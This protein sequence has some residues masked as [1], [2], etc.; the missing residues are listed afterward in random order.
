M[1]FDN[2]K[3]TTKMRRDSQRVLITVLL[4]LISFLLGMLTAPVAPVE[5]S[6]TPQNDP[7]QANH[8]PMA[9]DTLR[10]IEVRGSESYAQAEARSVNT[11]AVV[12]AK[13]RSLAA[14]ADFKW[15]DYI[16]RLAKLES[17]LNP[18]AVNVNKNGTIDE[19]LFQ[20]NRHY[21]PDM[22]K[23][24]VFDIEC[25]TKAAMKAINE[26]HQT[27]WVADRAARSR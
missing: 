13:I 25:S 21:H 4:C 23:E 24:C 18:N 20:F 11:P 10:M 8:L 2:M 22:T 9:K 16:V 27:W 26:G 5:A 12:E 6:Q 3:V 1:R 14:A 15:P 7:G 17:S 19:G